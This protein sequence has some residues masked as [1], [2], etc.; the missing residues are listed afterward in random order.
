MRVDPPIVDSETLKILVI[1]PSAMALLL[2]WNQLF[3]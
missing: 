3:M 1:A 2:T